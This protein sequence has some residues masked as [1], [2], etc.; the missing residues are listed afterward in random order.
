MVSARRGHARPRTRSST[1]L[2]GSVPDVET[3]D[4]TPKHQSA[5]TT[6][7]RV[8]QW[9]R[10]KGQRLVE[11]HNDTTQERIH[12]DF[13]SATWNHST[14]HPPDIGQCRPAGRC[15]RPTLGNRCHSNRRL[16]RRPL[17]T[18]HRP[19]ATTPAQANSA[20]PAISK[21]QTGRTRRYVH[22]LNSKFRFSRSSSTPFS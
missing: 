17:K 10:F 19:P 3:G 11:R 1:I 13:R 8:L 21:H 20:L 6:P 15:L 16:V 12:P 9:Y 2:A 4:P 18:Q 14:S 22:H 7:H 5:V